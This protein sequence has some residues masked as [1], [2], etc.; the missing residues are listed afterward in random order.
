MAGEV[1][2]W[3]RSSRVT[4]VTMSAF[5]V[6]F[7]AIAA[8]WLTL[9]AAHAEA[10]ALAA[11]LAVTITSRAGRV[12]AG[13]LAAPAVEW[14][15]AGCA[16]AA[17][18]VAYTGMAAGV[19]IHKGAAGLAGPAAT[20]LRGTFV[21]GFGG[22]GNTGIWRLAVVAA[23]LSVLLPMV[24]VCLYGPQGS[25]ATSPLLVFGTPADVRLPLAGL[26]VLL[27]GTRAG[28]LLVI[29]LGVAALGAAVVDGARAGM[30]PVSSG[31]YRG[32]GWLSIRI[33][34]L[35]GGR[36]LPLPPL[37]VGLL[38]TGMLAA[39]GLRNLPGILI[40]TPAEAMLLAALGSSHPHN[41]RGDWLVPPLIQ[42]AEYVILAELG[43][44]TNLW[45]PATFALIAA[46]GLRH[47]DLAYRALGNLASGADTRGL[48]W[49]GRLL[50]AS[51][52]VVTGIQVVV[53]PALTIYLWWLLF[54][55][56]TTGWPATTDQP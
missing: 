54:R 25:W 14:G 29:V 16:V 6:S 24:E 23:I 35:V 12:M 44:A 10:V 37:L 1:A 39:L 20:A 22:A 46:V 36:L 40:F 30:H 48:G 33:G 11:L 17:E 53:F 43:F 41:G 27:A 3:A 55:D 15:V 8:V 34:Q 7:A 9:A 38:V 31:G 56:S 49:E 19:T 26:A 18:L 42:A 51:F 52:A 13:R 2:R 50:L 47:L 45:P 32:D 5:A 21:A 4:P 28:F